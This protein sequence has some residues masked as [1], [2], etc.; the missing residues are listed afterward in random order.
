MTHMPF[1]TLADDLR[2]LVDATDAIGQSIIDAG[3]IVDEYD[4]LEEYPDAIKSINRNTTSIDITKNGQYYAGEENTITTTSFP[5]TIQN[6]IGTPIKHVTVD[7]NMQQNGT[8]T[9][10]NPI[11]PN[12][13][14]DR[15]RNLFDNETS[16]GY[17]NDSGTL[18]SDSTTSH[19]TSYIP[20]NGGATYTASGLWYVAG[21][22]MA[23]FAVYEWDSNKNWL[24]RSNRQYPP[25]S[26]R[27]T[28]TIGANTAYITLQIQTVH[29]NIMLN[30]GST[31]LPYEPYGYKIGVSSNNTTAPVYLG[32]VQTTRKIKKYE[33]TG[34]ENISDV[35][36]Y[37]NTNVSVL[38]I[39][40][41]ATISTTGGFQINNVGNRIW[42]IKSNFSSYATAADFKSYLA[43][44]YAAGTPVTVWY[45]LAEP[46]TG[47]VNEPIRKIGDY[48]DTVSADIKLPL[49]AIEPNIVDVDTSLKP[50]SASF[51]YNKKNEYI[52][53]NEINVNVPNTYTA[54]DEG[55]VVNNATLVAQ[56]AMPTEITANDTYDTT[57]Y[58]S[59][60]VNIPLSIEPKD[61]TFYD[62][63][64]SVV[65]T[66]TKDEFLALTELPRNPSH[67]GLTSQGWNWSL[68]DAK[69]YVNKYDKLD[70]GQM[71]VTDDG[72]TRIYITLTEGRT[73]PILQLYLN[74]NSELDID[75]GDG[76]AH[77]TFTSTSADYVSERHN[78]STP[79]DYVIA[80]TV[81]TGSFTL[82]SSS[83]NVSSILWNGNNNVNSP[84]KAYNNSIQK[85]EIGT[86][87]N[88]IGIYAFYQ[89]SSLSSITIPGGV[90]S[91]GGNA[92]QS[93]CSLSSITI[94]NSVTNIDS[95]AFAGC[96]SLSSIII[97]NGVKSIGNNAF[98]GCYSLTSITIPNSITSISV[99]AFQNCSSLSSI[100]IPNSI[101][102]IDSDTFY[103]CSSLT[104]ITISN[105][106]KN[107]GQ[108]AFAGCYSLSSVTIGNSVVSI[109]NSAFGDCSYMESIKFKSIT[110]PRVSN[111]NA[112]YGIPTSCIILVP[113]NAYSAYTSATNY[114][115]SSSYL[116][117]MYNT[118][119]SGNTL[120]TI[121]A[122][123]YQLTWYASAADVIS[124][125]N[126][127]TTGNGNEVYATV[128]TYTRNID[129]NNNT[130]SLAGDPQTSK[131]YSNIT[132]CTVQ[133]DGTVTSY[134][135]DDNY[136]EDGSIGQVMVRVPKFY[137]KMTPITLEAVDSSNP[138]LGNH[139]RVGE[140]SIS[141]VPRPGYKLHPAFINENG[142]E[143][144]CFYMSAFES[145]IYNSTTSTY[146]TEDDQV[147]GSGTAASNYLLSSI[148]NVRPCSGS[149][150]NLTR[151]NCEIMANN[152]GTGW[153]SC[154]YTQIAAVQML[155]VVE[156][157]ANSQSA[158]AN[159]VAFGSDPDASKNCAVFT[160]S[161]TGNTTGRAT[162]SIPYN[163]Y[164]TEPQPD[165]WTATNR[166]SC[167]W[168]GL[169]N[170][171]GNIW[172]H[173]M[174]VTVRG[175][176]SQRGGI[177]Y[178]CTDFNFSEPTLTT[179]PSNYVSP[180]FT[181][182]NTS[183]YIKAFGYGD[184][185]YD[186]MFFGSDT[187][188]TASIND[189]HYITANLNGNRTAFLG[190]FWS[191]S[192]AAGLFY[193]YVYNAVGTRNR[194]IGA[195]LCYMP[196]A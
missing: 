174:G 45:V 102:S 165:K 109:G 122:D 20:V 147:I 113:I 87:V 59:I 140:W 95:Y 44:Q 68:A 34:G 38:S 179:F 52:G 173:I 105:S 42:A 85:I 163:Y 130:T 1:N 83:T 128:T 13:T 132:R 164:T 93:C 178:V 57:L 10:Q 177:P 94:P 156:H 120:P 129:F 46:T 35:G 76:E 143:V 124:Q 73:S 32:E 136:T 139:I 16:S 187:G 185:Q 167:N 79:G 196:Q 153:H 2:R 55:K 61:V 141:D 114:P 161:T 191:H 160:G 71:Y 188:T 26:N 123:G 184:P 60:T 189:Y 145:S 183:G 9:P 166:T 17:Y 74:A 51:T 112:W 40:W 146:Y 43:A 37:Y 142:D 50:S 8:P 65:Y 78:Y 84:D 171:W 169:E 126:P 104:S 14:G 125:T 22:G 96:Y 54:E 131:V 89:C 135:G 47:I 195:R 24:R 181:I 162:E 133:D 56:T 186:W 101:T 5:I 75:W 25:S 190:G 103:R 115:D 31:A 3:G 111:S 86:G 159:G 170:L 91:I 117:I 23:N 151:T 152:R 49:S 137:Y 64:G 39:A 138:D 193:W 62:Y 180:G 28:F 116:Y 15:T 69:T 21:P 66:Y 7:G 150:Q 4:R 70:I 33:F 12:E 36:D 144:D 88:S 182:T 81:T 175:D 134:F 27:I 72:K 176:G 157:G 67:T 98:Y 127:I 63:D 158:I 119:P 18:V 6:S 121:S 29:G 77:S 149:S 118:Y 106:V 19:S 11:Q 172:A 48:V 53:Y 100:T 154:T 92:F 192:A 41:S 108:T 97:P 148:A 99:Y 194:Y 58:N 110:P 80:I 168:R 107:I 155:I 90:I 82:Q 30:S